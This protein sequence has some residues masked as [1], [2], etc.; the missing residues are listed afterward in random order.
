MPSEKSK[1]AVYAKLAKNGKR[2]ELRGIMLCNDYPPSLKDNLADLEKKA[3]TIRKDSNNKKK[4]KI[5]LKGN[6]LTLLV[7]GKEHKENNSVE[8]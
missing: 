7:D 5:V 2:P 8:I 6:T 3:Y 4:T 1:A